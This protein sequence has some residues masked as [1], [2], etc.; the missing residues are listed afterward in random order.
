MPFCLAFFHLFS[1]NRHAPARRRRAT[2][3]SDYLGTRSGRSHRADR[4]HEDETGKQAKARGKLAT[5]TAVRACKSKV[6]PVSSL[7]AVG[8]N[9]CGIPCAVVR[10]PTPPSARCCPRSYLSTKAGSAQGS[11]ILPVKPQEIRVGVE[12]RLRTGLAI[13]NCNQKFARS[14][15][16][17]DPLMT[18][19]ASAVIEITRTVT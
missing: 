4:T 12:A 14:S 13:R 9:N 2:I 15:F 19:S 18:A 6:T 17:S 10:E 7:E 5:E 16:L 3:D 8:R 11:D 1:A